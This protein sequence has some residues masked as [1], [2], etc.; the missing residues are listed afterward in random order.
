MEAEQFDRGLGPELF[1]GGGVTSWSLVV[2]AGFP[3]N[4]ADS[5]KSLLL[6]KKLSGM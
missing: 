5:R 1:P 3:G 2:S 6:A 4:H